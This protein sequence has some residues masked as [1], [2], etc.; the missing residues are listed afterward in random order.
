MR[1]SSL[2]EFES[3]L[4]ATGQK[5]LFG[6]QFGGCH[7]E[8]MLENADAILL[9]RFVATRDEGAFA[10]LVRRHLDGV[11]SA[12]LRRVG[13]DAQLAE[14]VAQQVFVALARKAATVARHGAVTGW[15]Y[16]AT[17]HE[18]A[19]VVRGER[20]RKTR[21]TEAHLIHEMLGATGNPGEADW[22]RVA[23]VLDA[24]ID[25]LGENDREAILARFV[26]RRAFAE[27]GGA[28]RISE[29]AARMRV[30]RALE[31]LRAVLARRGVTST[32]AALGAVL[33]E[34]AVGAAPVALAGTVVGAATAGGV[35]VAGLVGGGGMLAEIFT[36]MIT[37]KIVVGVAIVCAV[38]G[39]GSAVYQAKEVAHA[40][41][42]VMAWQRKSA[43]AE[44]K[45]AELALK[46]RES[47]ASA[48][49]A[50]ERMAALEAQLA[51]VKK[52]VAGAPANAA[53]AAPRATFQGV[54]WGNPDYAR[55]YVE[56]YRVGLGLR[57]GPLYRALNLSPEQIRKFEASL[58]EGQQG[59]VDV[60]VEVTKQGLPTGGNSA[61]STSVAR[62]TSGPLGNMENSLKEL[63]GEAGFGSF[64]EFEKAKGNRELIASLA[65]TLYTSEAPLTAGQGE[66]LAAVLSSNTRRDWVPMADDGKKQLT[67]LSEV[68]DWAGVQ[69][70]AQAFLSAPQLAALKALSDQKQLDQE[71]TKLA[72]VG[73]G[74]AAAKSTA[75]GGK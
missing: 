31:K 3:H 38:V 45:A 13:G 68:T 60:W 44:V 6:F 59:V 21:E 17:R 18:A 35:A 28:L 70:Q 71:M 62:L 16:R 74:A 20:R 10:E 32:G 41:A 1:R 33:A 11:Y 51:V 24:A 54:S 9:L 5:T 23:P 42:A 61:A 53:P 69:K 2:A 63:L 43:A 55:T 40:N 72:V 12:A 39:I 36:F 22:S 8:T 58:T 25:E 56:K 14:D 7:R 52:T 50:A 73:V 75:S 30:E 57:Y 48:R 29:D 65:G 15:L 64:K 34:Q 19:N 46:M 4:N 47:E 49:A 27:M 67:R 26:E 37:G 66:S